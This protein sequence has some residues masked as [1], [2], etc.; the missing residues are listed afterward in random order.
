MCWRSRRWAGG[1]F[2][3]GISRI[4]PPFESC[5]I[6]VSW[7]R[8]AT[9]GEMFVQS[10]MPPYFETISSLHLKAGN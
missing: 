4:P 10:S 6:Q 2:A 7:S 1:I 9:S 5:G 8:P 3:S